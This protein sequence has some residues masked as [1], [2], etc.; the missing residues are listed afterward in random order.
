MKFTKGQII[1]RTEAVYPSGALAVDGYDQNGR[2]LAHPLSG[3]F[4]LRFERDA[5]RQFRVVTRAEQESR[6]WR[7]SR[8]E[9]EGTE[10][11]FVGW[12]DGTRWSGWAVPYFEFAEAQRV[13][14]L[15]AQGE[16][17]F[18]PKQDCFVTQNAQGEDQIWKGRLI[19]MAGG[20]QVKVYGV[21]AGAWIWERIA[22]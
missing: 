10:Q 4:Q 8:F 18:D 9:I 3:G 17:R 14:K 21:G 19:S 15:V 12:T 6:P 7:R 11:R 20:K 13:I 1:V 5:Q 16:G 22:D 2:L